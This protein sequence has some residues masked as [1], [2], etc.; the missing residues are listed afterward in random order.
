MTKSPLVCGMVT[1]VDRWAQ[2]GAWIR[3][4]AGSFLTFLIVRITVDSVGLPANAMLVTPSAGLAV[5]FGIV[6]G[7]PAAIGLFAAVFVSQ[8]FQSGILLF[9]VVEGMSL[10]ALA[11]TAAIGWRAELELPAGVTI[12][13]EGVPGFVLVT[14]VGTVGAGA[15]LAWG[16]ELLGLFPFY[17]AFVDTLLRYLVA[18]VVVGSAITLLLLTIVESTHSTS[19]PGQSDVLGAGFVFVPVLWGG[20]GLVGSLGFSIRERIP[21]AVFEEFGIEVL[22]HLVHP[23]V[24]GSGGRRVQVV[25]G[26]VMLL[27]WVY[28]VRTSKLSK[29]EARSHDDESTA[30]LEEEQRAVSSRTEDMEV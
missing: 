11:M 7:L 28:T 9:G 5:P 24:F 2:S 23:D 21:R 17:V 8:V 29:P 20:L 22:Y 30:S 4:I 16:G 1:D 27:I 6:F 10:F 25:F 18:T 3:I 12:D 19:A 15:V 13:V 26:S 14:A